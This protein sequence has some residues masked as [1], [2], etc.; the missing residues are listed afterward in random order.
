MF[1]W[2]KT[3]KIANVV[4]AVVSDATPCDASLKA[5]VAP[6]HEVQSM[7]Y[8][9]IFHIKQESGTLHL[10]LNQVETLWSANDFRD[11]APALEVHI[12]RQVLEKTFPDYLSLH[13]S[14]VS[15]GESAC[16][17]AASSGSGKSSLCTAA[18][19]DGASYFTDEFSLLAT[20]GEIYPFPRPLQWDGKE[21]PAFKEENMVDSGCFKRASFSFV[22]AGSTAL[23]TSYLWLPK[24]VQRAPLPLQA[25][26]IPKYI[27]GAAA[28][29]V[30][31]LRRGEALLLLQEHMHQ[32]Y[33]RGSDI[34]QLNQRIP[35]DCEFYTL[36]YS[37]V[38]KAWQ[39]IKK[40][41]LSKANASKG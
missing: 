39:L 29:E 19:L 40:G 21:H 32:H 15:V 10:I 8:D 25:I 9:V 14:C 20:G 33:P 34:Q 26:V 35:R 7:A 16:M 13:A 12:Y 1:G 2:E 24:H 22:E 38:R 30:Y 28:A 27:E 37:D 31:E 18:L 11:I 4:V 6:Y 5:I 23:L 17:F 41:L 36:P 3:F